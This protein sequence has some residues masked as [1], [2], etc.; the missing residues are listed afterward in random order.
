MGLH[1][2]EPLLT[3]DR[4]RYLGL[5][6]HQAARIE[7]AAHGGRVLLSGVTAAAVQGS[8]PKGVEFRRLGE[9]RLKD[10]ERPESLFQ[11]LVEDLPSSF[12]PLCTTEPEPEEELAAGQGTNAAVLLAGEPGTGKTRLAEELATEAR[13]DGVT[14]LWGRCWEGEG[15]PPFFP[16]IQLLQAYCEQQS[17]LTLRAELGTGAP[18]LA[19]LLPDLR[20]KW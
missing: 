15:A 2:G 13:C 4:D 8:L 11:L 19:Q 17:P 9:H 12:A 10:F 16:W 7:A 6:V 5:D 1:T 14:V 3:G 20:G 18:T